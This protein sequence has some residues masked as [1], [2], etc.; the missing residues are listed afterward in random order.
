MK[1][2]LNN[3]EEEIVDMIDLTKEIC[4]ELR[5]PFLSQIGLKE[6]IVQ[7]IQRF[8]LRVNVKVE[9]HIH[10]STKLD[11]ERELAVYRIIQELLNNALKHS[12]ASH[13]QLTLKT[14]DEKV[15]LHY[16]DNGIGIDM[17]K[18]N[19]CDGK[20]GLFGIKERVKA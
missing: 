17:E 14:Y 9:W 8:Q 5:P 2:Q 3:I 4:H 6:A 10:L 7:L 20:L 19:H 18:L 15:Q 1:K 11:E 13:I 12:Q 16:V